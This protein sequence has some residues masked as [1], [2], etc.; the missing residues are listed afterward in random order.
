MKIIKSVF[1]ESMSESPAIQ[2]KYLKYKQKYFNLKKMIGGGINATY[3]ITGVQITLRFFDEKTNKE[4]EIKYTI[5]KKLSNRYANT[6]VYKIKKDDDHTNTFIF[7]KGIDSGEREIHREGENSNLL[8]NILDDDMLVLFQGTKQSDFLISTYNGNDLYQEFKEKEIKEFKEQYANVTTQLLDL[9]H[10]INSRDIFHN[11]I[12]LQNITIKDGKVYL[13]DFE[14]LTK[15]ESNYGTLVSMSFNGVIASL[16][17]NNYNNYSKKY[18]KLQLI[19]KNKNTDMVGFFYCCFDLLFLSLAN[20]YLS[21]Y[22]FDYFKIYSNFEDVHM[23]KL[24]DLF[25]FILPESDL[26]KNILETPDYSDYSEYKNLPSEEEAKSIFGN[27]PDENTNLFRFMA[28]IY[29]KIKIDLIKNKTQQIWYKD[30]LKIMSACF[31]PEFNYDKFETDFKNIVSKFSELPEIQEDGFGSDSIPA[32]VPVGVPEYVPGML[33]SEIDIINIIFPESDFKKEYDNGDFRISTLDNDYCIGFSISRRHNIDIF[34]L[35]KCGRNITG[36]IL[37]EKINILAQK[38]NIESI[39]VL[40]TSNIN[41]CSKPISLSTIKILTKGESWYNS[42][43]YKST[44]YEDEVKHNEKIIDMLYSDFKEKLLKLYIEEL[45]KKN[46]PKIL[47]IKQS[48]IK[49]NI[50][51]LKQNIDKLKKNS[52][53]DNRLLKIK[54]GEYNRLLKIK[55]GEYKTYQKYIDDYST[56]IYTLTSKK[57]KEYKELIDIDTTIFSDIDV[58]SNVKVKDYFTSIWSQIKRNDCNEII[59]KQLDWLS[60]IISIIDTSKILQY[61]KDLIKTVIQKSPAIQNKYLK[62]KQKYLNL[63]NQLD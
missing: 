24:F 45:I 48:D 23:Y 18:N 63:K 16:K 51:K 46:S 11:D 31:L 43:G 32:R 34:T 13:I 40:D 39:S 10:K 12:K 61:N 5:Q 38:L 28:F 57:K 52:G 7:K 1:P 30:F 17:K 33:Q 35:N 41:E 15:G 14:L 9:L 27:F 6:I 2:N 42:L 37:L 19:L 8:K 54:E 44:H 20:K 26:K 53:Q 21:S 55:E 59:I 29:S 4:K 49:Q 3:T 58:N 47:K 36:T 62:Y 60:N 25:F 22:I 50:D 56:F